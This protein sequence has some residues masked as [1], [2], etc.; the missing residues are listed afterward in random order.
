MDRLVQRVNGYI[1]LPVNVV[2]RA[3]GRIDSRAL[4][5]GMYR[6]QDKLGS[7][8]DPDVTNGLSG[9]RAGTAPPHPLCPTRPLV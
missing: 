3:G 2:R 5:C 7:W 1:G 6:D 9:L 8:Y 4:L